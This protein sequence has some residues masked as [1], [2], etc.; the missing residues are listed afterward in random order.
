MRKSFTLKEHK[1]IYKGRI[2]DLTV[3][4]ITT[5]SGIE[6]VREVI[7]HTGGVALIPILPN[8]EILLVKQF[9]YP[10]QRSLLELPAGKIDPGEAP[11]TTAARELEEEVGFTAGVLKKLSEFYTSPGFCDEK[12][13]LYLATDLEPSQS[14]GDDDE[15]IEI[16]SYTLGELRD[17]IERAEIVDAKTIIGVQCLLLAES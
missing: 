4:A 10:M 15:E 8:G 5:A 6:T 3:D 2:I 14:M 13:F 12:I 1:E 9:R 7:H 17:L 11:E 16:A